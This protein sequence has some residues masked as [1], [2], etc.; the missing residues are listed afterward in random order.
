M[1]LLKDFSE[2]LTLK[3]A[4]DKHGRRLSPEDVNIL[5]D[6]SIIF[7][8]DEIVWIGKSDK[9]PSN[10]NYTKTFDMKGFCLTPEIVDSHTHLVF[11]GNRANEYLMRLNGADYQDIANAGGG[12]LASQK[13]TNRLND[14][15]LFHESVLKI[16][17][18][19][20]LG[21]GTIEIKSG[22]GLTYK[23]EKRITLIIDKLKKHFAPKINI[24]NTF[25]A[26][27]AVPQ[28]YNSSH[29]YINQVVIPLLNDPEIT[30]KIDAIDIFHEKGYFDTSDVEVVFQKAKELNIHTKIHADEFND[31]NGAALAVKYKSLSCDHLLA[32]SEFGIKSLANSETVACLLP[33][34]AFFLGKHQVNARKFLDNGVKVAIASDYNPGS[35]HL[36][37]LLLIATLSAPTYKMNFAELWSSITLNAAHSLGLQKQGAIIE[38]LKPRFTFFKTESIAEITY[39]S[40]KNLAVNFDFQ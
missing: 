7:N 9:I 11:G 10:I 8:K 28:I 33:G 2:I 5:K 29:D 38:G 25:M 12:I 6:A 14:E 22:Y 17:R 36:D 4:F 19:Y 26:A 39:N 15:E 35:C 20:S 1:I 31:N 16:E 40:T 27:H 18:L 13:G 23:D 3:G 21:V 37:N 24:F 32:T 30:T 34:T